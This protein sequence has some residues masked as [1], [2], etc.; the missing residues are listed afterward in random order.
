MDTLSIELSREK[1][2][3]KL[4]EYAFIFIDQCVEVAIK[5]A[6]KNKENSLAESIQWLDKNEG[7]KPDGCNNNFW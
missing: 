3:K 5:D 4:K 7:S 1:L 6:M 2:D